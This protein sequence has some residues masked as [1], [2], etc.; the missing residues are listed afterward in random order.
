L[1]P[2]SHTRTAET[3][4]IYNLYTVNIQYIT[5]HSWLILYTPHC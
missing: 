4:N 5:T 1:E 2:Q 3:R